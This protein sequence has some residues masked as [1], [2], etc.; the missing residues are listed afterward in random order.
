MDDGPELEWLSIAEL[1]QLQVAGLKLEAPELDEDSE[2]SEDSDDEE[3]E[4][5]A[6]AQ[7]GTLTETEADEEEEL[8]GTYPELLET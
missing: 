8:E 5:E 7:L 1:D 3:L 2:D 4:E 6:A